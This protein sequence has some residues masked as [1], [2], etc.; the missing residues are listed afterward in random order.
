MA[1]CLY[2]WVQEVRMMRLPILLYAFT[3]NARSFTI[4]KSSKKK[5]RRLN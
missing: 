4:L 2:Q 1:Q 5:S 3:N